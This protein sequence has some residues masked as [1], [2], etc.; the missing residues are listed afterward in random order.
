MT[1]GYYIILHF[2]VLYCTTTHFHH[3]S[4][5]C[6]KT[7][8][9]VQI[10]CW[11]CKLQ[12]IFSLCFRVWRYSFLLWGKCVLKFFLSFKVSIFYTCSSFI[13]LTCVCIDSYFFIYVGRSERT[14]FLFPMWSASYP[15]PSDLQGHLCLIHISRY[16]GAHFWALI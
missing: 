11:L 8:F 7:L 16:A 6:W 15:R 1:S 2:T 3:C 12:T 10:L 14:C 13:C 5:F 9:K 4:N